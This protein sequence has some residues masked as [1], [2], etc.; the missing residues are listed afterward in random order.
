MRSGIGRLGR[1][2][3]ERPV[4]DDTDR[5]AIQL[6]GQIL[7]SSADVQ[8]HLDHPDVVTR[9]GGTDA[10][11]LWAGQQLRRMPLLG[12][13]GGLLTGQFRLQTCPGEPEHQPILRLS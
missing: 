8:V 12:R 5:D 10:A 4:L 2:G 13:H 3:T 6:C 9:S 7:P 1:P 11:H